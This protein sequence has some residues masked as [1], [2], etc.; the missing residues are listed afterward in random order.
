MDPSSE[1]FSQFDL[2]M[3]VAELSMCEYFP[4]D[5][6]TRAAIMRLL[7]RICPHE[8]ALR[9]LVRTFVDRIGRWHG[10]TE[11]RAVL[12]TR[13]RPA[14]GV[15]PVDGLAP[16]STLPGFRPGDS[17]ES[18]YDAH[19]QLKIGWTQQAPPKQIAADPRLRLVVRQLAAAKTIG[20]DD[21]SA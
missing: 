18:T 9:W 8:E 11:L 7:A 17:E 16:C 3:A 1:R 10:P 14:D 12:A 13:Y 6:P 15:D 2:E 20:D 21:V 5:D 4:T 19:E